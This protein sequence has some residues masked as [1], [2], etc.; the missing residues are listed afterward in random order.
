[1]Y[2]LNQ[3]T[4]EEKALFLRL[5]KASAKTAIKVELARQNREKVEKEFEEYKRNVNKEK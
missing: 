4:D 3:M 2:N 5:V 1:M